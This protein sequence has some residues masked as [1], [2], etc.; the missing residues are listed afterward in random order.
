MV[1]DCYIHD[2]D[3]GYPRVLARRRQYFVNIRT[4]FKNKIYVQLSKRCID[5]STDNNNSDLFTQR[6]REHLR[7]LKISGVKDCAD[8]ID[9]LETKIQGMD[10]EIKILNSKMQRWHNFTL[11]TNQKI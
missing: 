7:S 3:L 10:I 4:R 9:F 5:Y 1:R 6:G 2:K 11:L 8:T